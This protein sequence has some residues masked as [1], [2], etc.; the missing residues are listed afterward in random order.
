VHAPCPMDDYVVS[1]RRINHTAQMNGSWHTCE[2][3]NP[4]NIHGWDMSLGWILPSN[5]H[6]TLWCVPTCA[7]CLKCV[8]VCCNVL[9]CVAVCCSVDITCAGV[10]FECAVPHIRINETCCTE[11]YHTQTHT[12]KYANTHMLT[13]SHTHTHQPHPPTHTPT[14]TNLPGFEIRSS[15]RG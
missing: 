12:L 1:H 9:Q 2:W 3:D 11:Q 6:T 4:M 10:H 7:I 14:H 5:M 13:H 15:I 8:A